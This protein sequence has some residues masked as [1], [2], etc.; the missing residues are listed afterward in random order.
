MT[1]FAQW[2]KTFD[3]EKQ[4]PYASWELSAKDGTPH[5]INSDVVKEAILSAPANE[6]EQLRDMLVR[7]DFANAD[8]NDFYRHLAQALVNGL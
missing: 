8:I 1:K 7:L 3:E 4:T 6:Q 5:F 2:F